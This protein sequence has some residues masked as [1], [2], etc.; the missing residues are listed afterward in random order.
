MRRRFVKLLRLKSCKRRKIMTRNTTRKGVPIKRKAERRRP[1]RMKE[2]KFECAYCGKIT[3]G[4]KPKRGD[5]TGRY[6]RKHRADGRICEGT[7]S[8]ANWVDVENGEIVFR[9][10]ERASWEL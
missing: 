1:E 4:R 7:F 3:G 10:V 9:S 2:T 6:P 8:P 5:G